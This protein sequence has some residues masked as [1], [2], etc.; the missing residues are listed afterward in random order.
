MFKNPFSF[1]GKIGRLEYFISVILF[2]ILIS[3]SR[4]INSLGGEFEQYSLFFYAFTYWIIFAQ[5]TKRCHDLNNPG[6]TQLVPLYIIWLLFVGGVQ[7]HNKSTIY[8]SNK[9][10]ENMKKILM[11]IIAIFL[12]AFWLITKDVRS[13]YV[14][15]AGSICLIGGGSIIIVAM[16]KSKKIEK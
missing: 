3:I 10:A 9:N 1:E 2:I 4:L 13:M 7:E 14:K 16:T 5:G 12:I 8:V 6:W 15:G 11:I